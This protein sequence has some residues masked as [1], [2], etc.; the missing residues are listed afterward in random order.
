MACKEILSSDFVTA[1]FIPRIM[2]PNFQAN[3]WL[4]EVTCAGTESSI[5]GIK[6]YSK[7]IV[8]GRGWGYINVFYTL[9]KIINI[10]I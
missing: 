7:N 3:F 8:R 2:C 1:S 4:D 6:F 9:A 10:W 5:L